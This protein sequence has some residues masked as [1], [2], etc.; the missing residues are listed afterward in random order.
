MLKYL[1][2]DKIQIIMYEELRQ[3]LKYLFR[4]KQRNDNGDHRQSNKTSTK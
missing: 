2:H 4:K 3:R 1:H